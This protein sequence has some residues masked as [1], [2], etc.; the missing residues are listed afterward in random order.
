M[1]TLINWSVFSLRLNR[2]Y[3]TWFYRR[4]IMIVKQRKVVVSIS[5]RRR[6]RWNHIFTWKLWWCGGMTWQ[7]ASKL[8]LYVINLTCEWFRCTE[9]QVEPEPRQPIKFALQQKAQNW[10]QW[11]STTLGWQQNTWSS[12]TSDIYANNTTSAIHHAINQ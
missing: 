2:L 9:N 6:G 7:A 4:N 12:S 11:N 1:I 5:Y 3:S 8:N 10:S